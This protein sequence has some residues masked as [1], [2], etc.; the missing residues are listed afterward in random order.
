MAY[1]LPW[2]ELC[3]GLKKKDESYAR[4]AFDIE[5]AQLVHSARVGGCTCCT[6][7]LAAVEQ[8]GWA[9]WSNPGTGQPLLWN[10]VDQVARIYAYSQSSDEETLFLELYPKN[11]EPKRTL[12]LF[13]P[14]SGKRQFTHSHSVEVGTRLVPGWIRQLTVIRL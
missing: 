3:N 8:F 7:M 13:F 6:V 12:E 11:E 5:P 4:I 14:E 1:A 2:C 10:P 9:A